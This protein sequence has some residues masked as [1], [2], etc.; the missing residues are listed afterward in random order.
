M[1]K[2]SICNIALT[3]VGEQRII[4]FTDKSKNAILCNQLFDQV[5][6]EVLRNHPW[7]CAT[8][9]IELAQDAT[10]PIFGWTYRYALPNSPYCVKV[11]YLENSAQ[12]FAIEGRWLMTDQGTVKMKYIARPADV[13]D[14]DPLCTKVLYLSLA[15]AFAYNLVENNTVLNNL[16]DQQNAAYSEARSMDAQEGTVQWADQSAWLEA[17]ISRMP[18]GIYT[19]NVR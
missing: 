4:S 11:L 12:E 5:L 13:A 8:R 9:R 10:A 14:L 16:L 15:V 17:R 6:D 1:S 7:N 19:N 3:R 2:V 18:Y